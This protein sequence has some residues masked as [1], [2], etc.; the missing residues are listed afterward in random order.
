MCASRSRCSM[1]APGDRPANDGTSA[2]GVTSP[3]AISADRGKRAL[4]VSA[5]LLGLIVLSP[6]L[7][8]AG[9]LVW[10]ADRHMPLYIADRVGRGGRTFRMVKLRSMTVGAAQTGVDSTAAD[11]RRI[12]RV[13]RG[14]RRVKL[15][16]VTQLWNVLRGEMSLVGPR[17]QVPRDASLYTAQERGLLSVRP[18]ITDFASIVFSD[19]ARIL[20]GAGDP[21]LRYQ[22]LIRPWKSRLGL[23]Y[24]SVHSVWLDLRL[25]MAT[26]LAGVSRRRSLAWVGRMLLE[27]G[28][29]PRLVHVARRSGPL[30]PAPPPGATEVV[31]SREPGSRGR[32]T[33]GLAS[34]PAGSET[35]RSLQAS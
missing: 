13:G 16:E 17:P 2:S 4:D 28:A 20:A 31:R 26:A 35:A 14:L 10:L 22:Q 23:H 32:D 7:L 12:T 3:A 29:D 8:L 19:E 34:L 1:A 15:D 5:A 9:L 21:D 11:D 27:T 24:V 25:V 30:P 33:D 18:G 6:L